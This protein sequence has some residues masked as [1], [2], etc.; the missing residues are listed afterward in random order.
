MRSVTLSSLLC[1]LIQALPLSATETIRS[2]PP[3]RPLPA[4]T[5]RPLADGPSHFVDAKSG[6]DDADGSQGKPWKTLAHAIGRLKP[7]DTLYLRGGIY[8]E[9]I[10]VS[11]IGTPE[12]P[13]TI[14]SYP[15]EM[16]ILDGGIR[17]F[18]ENPDEAW[19]PSPE[20]VE[21]EYRS[22]KAFPNLGAGENGFNTHAWF[23]D[24]MV[25][26]QGYRFLKDLR[27]PS[28]A[29]DIKNK[30]G[31]ED[32]GVYCGP[33]VFYDMKTGR[34]HARLAHTTLK[35]LGDD[36]YR[37]ETD[38]RKLPLVVAAWKNGSVLTVRNARDMCFQDLV[39][40]G[41]S[42]FTIDVS[43]SARLMFDG[44]TVY[45]GQSAFR[46]RDT[47][48]LRMLHTACRGIA[49]PWTFR[50]HLK[51]RSS[52]ARLFSAGGWSPTGRDNRDFEFAYCE[53]TDSVDGVFVG[54]IK[55]VHFHHNLLDNISDDGLFLTS[56]TGY[57][58]VTPGGDVF[59][60]QN[61]LSRCLTTFAFGVGHGR[62]K[63]LESGR[64]TGS[65][66][67]VFRNVFDFRRPV[68]Y[69]FPAGPDGQ[70]E[71][72]SKGRFASD[73]GSPAWEPM[74]V[75]HNT[76][77][78][79]GPTGYDYGTLG[80][81]GGLRGGNVRRVFNNVVIQ[82]GK[83]PSTALV[84]NSP[85]LKVD[86]N[87][88]WSAEHGSAADFLTMFRKKN[89]APGLGDRDRFADPKF[90]TFNADWR[91]PIDLNVGPG[92]AAI[93]SGIDLPADWPDPVR[94]RDAGKPDVGALHAEAEA[95]RVGVRG[96]LSMFGVAEKAKEPPAFTPSRF[97]DIPGVV[98]HPDVKPAAI[99]EGYP[100]LDAPVIEYLLKRRSV[101][102]DV[103]QRS[104]LETDDYT[105]YRMVVI[106]GDLQRAGAK[107]DRYSAAD[108]EKV[109][110]FLA[111]GGT[112]WL[113]RRGKRVFDWSPEG[114]KFLQDV[115]G[116]KAEEEANPKMA[117]ARPMHP[118]LK[119]LDADGAYPWLAWRPDNDNAPLRAGQGERII[120][121]PG[122][123][124]LLYRV[125]VGKGQLIYTG[126]QV[127]DSIPNGR[128]A[129]AVAREKA[130][131]EQVKILSNVVE[132]VYSA[133]R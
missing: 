103:R 62:Q 61:V 116:R 55:G 115:T 68:M 35:A 27:D 4:T 47:F 94:K 124:C 81:T 67:H 20:G 36:N 73:H 104:W 85:D 82:L 33:G 42:T 1:A 50:G 110:K 108:V 86:G 43:D 7:G 71:L 91:A 107:P 32:G 113:L 99:V 112:L 25:P 45:G 58:G 111:D 127:A 52:E 26:M 12:K 44:L 6:R 77:I 131:E 46:V 24:S 121:S 22:T 19:E 75:Y 126:W 76:I 66:A 129:S 84:K 125:P 133:G 92:S 118:W 56:S 30:T 96:R 70:E 100:E 14:R 49:A 60:Y 29:W 64:Q 123:T 34:F 89:A 48:G 114:R 87:L 37:G 97:A 90:T 59:V 51:Y 2:H 57:D 78:S 128:L 79:D 31:D 3:T 101:P 5:S 106:A 109:R 74:N 9:R 21:G 117:F 65:G 83:F 54:N 41:S 132:D 39:V 17:E 122:D 130:L 80:L 28:M 11:V 119:H 98:F 93:D 15:T 13:I 18:F 120:A 8:S 10:T 53:F 102:V 38:P 23:G 69:Q 63:T 40:R 105:K 72:P 16:A 88:F 95:W